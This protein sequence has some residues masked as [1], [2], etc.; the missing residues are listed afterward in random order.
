MS[1]DQKTV[2][3]TVQELPEPWNI[4][5]NRLAKVERGMIEHGKRI[6]QLAEQ[7]LQAQLHTN[8]VNHD[9]ANATVES[10]DRVLMELHDKRE[11]LAIRRASIPHDDT[12]RI[13]L[14]MM[15]DNLAQ[16]EDRTRQ[17]RDQA[18]LKRERSKELVLDT[19]DRIKSIKAGDQSLAF[20]PIPPKELSWADK[21]VKWLADNVLKVAVIG[22]LVFIW[23][24]IKYYF[25]GKIN[26]TIP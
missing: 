25:I 12:E 2:Q 6:T 5:S 23:E 21:V 1:D 22:V 17:E 4:L 14:E 8:E 26:G 18:V 19:N 24:A 3:R 7:I 16:R 20:P 13:M 15:D 11:E 10:L 9:V